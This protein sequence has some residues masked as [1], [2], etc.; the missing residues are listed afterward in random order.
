MMNQDIPLPA[1]DASVA[2]MD[3]QLTLA[4]PLALEEEVLD[5]LRQHQ[6]LVPGFSVVH[7]QGLGHHAPLTTAM[8]RVE[9]RARRVFVHMVMRS[10]DVAPLVGRLREVLQSP[11]VFYWA[12]PLLASGRLA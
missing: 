6:D 12:V 10:G 11:Q 2:G 8:E 5:L 9:G 4:M 1:G 7:G 3:C